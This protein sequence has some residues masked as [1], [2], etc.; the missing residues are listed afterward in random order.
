MGRLF[1]WQCTT[2]FD[3]NLS[4]FYISPVHMGLTGSGA[5]KKF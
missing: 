2:V 4:V 3:I 5:L 1:V